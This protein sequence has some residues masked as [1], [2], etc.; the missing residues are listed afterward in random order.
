VS[1]STAGPIQALSDG[2]QSASGHSLRASDLVVIGYLLVE[3]A[4][5]VLFARRPESDWLLHLGINAAMIAGIYVLIRGA[6]RGRNRVMRIARD[7]Y[8]ALYVLAIFKELGVL[9]PAV[10]PATYDELLL[11]WDRAIFGDHPGSFFDAIS[12]PFVTEIMRG[13]WL[14]YFVL[15]FVVCVPLYL[16]E[17]RAAFDETVHALILGWLISYLGYYALPALGPGYFPDTIP[18]PECVNDPGVTQSVALTLFSLEGRMHDIFPSGHTIIALIA[19]WQ[20]ARHRLRWWPA[21]IPIVCGL[22]MGTVYLR[23]HYGVDVLAGFLIAA[24]VIA[25]VTCRA[26]PSACAPV[27]RGGSRWRPSCREDTGP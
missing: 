19:L 3:S 9:V 15:P 5:I 11:V 17:R 27:P 10:H 21:L 4:L 23:Y 13:C 6:G 25:F 14:S 1:P 22:V 2:A 20:A 8:P 18:A 26:S 12:S 24:A 16:R 7:W